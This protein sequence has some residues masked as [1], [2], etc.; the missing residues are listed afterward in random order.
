[1]LTPWLSRTQRLANSVT[2]SPPPRRQWS[3]LVPQDKR[4]WPGRSR[5]GCNCIV[6]DALTA[7]S[8]PL[9]G[10]SPP[11]W[12]VRT[13]RDGK[14]SDYGNVGVSPRTLPLSAVKSMFVPCVVSNKL[15]PTASPCPTNISL[16]ASLFVL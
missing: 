4:S 9:L 1:M 12:R 10:A 5:H 7:S 8:K 6:A 14:R 11:T 13:A 2:P 3:W 15:V 16:A